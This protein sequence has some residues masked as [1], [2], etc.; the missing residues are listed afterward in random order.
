MREQQTEAVAN[1]GDQRDKEKQPLYE[2]EE[3]SSEA[4]GTGTFGNSL[5]RQGLEENKTEDCKAGEEWK[6]GKCSHHGRSKRAFMLHLGHDDRKHC[7]GGGI[8]EQE[9]I[10]IGLKEIHRFRR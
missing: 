6:A 8:N 4:A 9:G 3:T 2:V 1:G 7:I 10:F 5:C